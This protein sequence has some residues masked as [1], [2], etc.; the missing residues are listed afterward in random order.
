MARLVHELSPMQ[1]FTFRLPEEEAETL[2]GMSK[3]THR[4]NTSKLL[5]DM[6]GAACSGSPEKVAQFNERLF[7][8]IG[9]Q[10]TLDMVARAAPKRVAPKPK[11]RGR[12]AKS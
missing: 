2:R 10:L 6:V 4:G 11:K 1:V 12:R 3:L 5:R 9:R 8:A 7:G